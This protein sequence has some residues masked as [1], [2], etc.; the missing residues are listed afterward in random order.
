MHTA[1]AAAVYITDR[2]S[3]QH[4]GRRL[5]LHP[6]T[7]TYDEQP[8]A[9]LVCRLNALLYCKKLADICSTR[10]GCKLK[11]QVFLAL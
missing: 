9:A 11:T 10:N 3:V 5:S 1:A 2:A 7:L 6:Q 8:Y 4:I